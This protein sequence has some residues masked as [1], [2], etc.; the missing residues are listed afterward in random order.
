MVEHALLLLLLPLQC[1]LAAHAPACGSRACGNRTR[2][3]LACI[4]AREL[5]ISLGLLSGAAVD[6]GLQ[7]EAAPTTLGCGVLVVLLDSSA[8]PSGVTCTGVHERAAAAVKDATAQLGHLQRTAA[9]IVLLDARPTATDATAAT[10]G[11]V[12]VEPEELTGAALALAL[13]RVRHHDSTPKWAQPVVAALASG[14]AQL[15]FFAAQSSKHDATTF[16]QRHEAVVLSQLVASAHR[17][18][19]P[20]I[21]FEEGPTPSSSPAAPAPGELNT[22]VLRTALDMHCMGVPPLDDART[23]QQLVPFQFVPTS[24]VPDALAAA[25]LDTARAATVQLHMLIERWHH[26]ADNVDFDEEGTAA[27]HALLARGAE[28]SP[29]DARSGRTAAE[30]TVLAHDVTKLRALL[31]L[32][33]SPNIPGTRGEL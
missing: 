14:E 30:H 12:E 31:T 22:A 26:V 13:G 16:S 27:A 7:L 25:A 19:P 11:E 17:L 9:R 2:R 5:A 28:L 3:E 24:F 33:L 18:R 29:W 32:G 4:D 8:G 1:L 6:D 20:A 15:W 21:F 23:W 10:A